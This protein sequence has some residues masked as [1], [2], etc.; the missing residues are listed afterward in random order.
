MSS[1]DQINA[2][3]AAGLPAAAATLSDLGRRAIFP[4][5]IPFQ[6]AQARGTRYNGTIGQVT[7]GYGKPVPM[8]SIRSAMEGL[9]DGMC[10]L[11]SPPSG[12]LAL[13]QAWAAR[14]REHSG[15]A[16]T[17]FTTPFFTCGLSQGLSFIGDLFVEPGRPVLV[18]APRWGNYDQT[19]GFRRGGTL[20]PYELF[21]DGDFSLDPLDRALAALDGP[22]VIV[23][24][25]PNNPTG[26]TPSR[27]QAAALVERLA[28]HRHPLVIVVD[29]AYAGM[30]YEPTALQRSLFWELAPVLDP[31]FHALFRIDGVT[32]ELLFFPGRVGFLTTAL[33]PDSPA[34]A[35]LESKLASLA[36]SSVGSPT[37]PGQA[38]VLRALQTPQIEDQVAQAHA[39]L[40]ARYLA[41]RDAIDAI[42]HPAL[43]PFPFNSGVFALIGVSGA[44]DVDALRRFLIDDQSVGVVAIASPPALRIA[45]CSV[46]EQDL[47]ELVRRLVTGVERYLARA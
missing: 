19:F 34:A 47:P 42:D 7:D 21:V 14:Q 1:L 12:H 16:T 33:D 9:D 39:M 40:R 38:V 2:D 23:L 6:S 18:P 30:V 15:G 10:H 43:Q 5:G 11:Y 28:A 17:L 32:K 35:A 24:N 31:E 29:D 4:Q 36:R 20:V 41:L 13:R 44:E 27:A 26:F 45:Y 8:P 37:G 3:F 22:A 25:F 46:A